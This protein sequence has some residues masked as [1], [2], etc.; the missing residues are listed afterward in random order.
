MRGLFGSIEKRKKPGKARKRP[1]GDT[2][3]P[4]PVINKNLFGKPVSTKGDVLGCDGCPLNK[5]PGTNKVKRLEYITGR[6]AMLWAMCPGRWENKREKELVGKSGEFLWDTLESFDLHRNSFDVQNVVRCQ[7]KINPESDGDKNNRE[8]TKQELLCCS[9][10]N[11][12]ALERNQGRAKVHL[13][14]GE[15]AATQLLGKEFK[16]KRMI[17]WHKGW[18]C[19]IV[20]NYHPSYFTRQKGTLGM[21]YFTWRDR[22]RAVAAIIQNPGRWGYLKKQDYHTVRTLGEFDEMEKHLREEAAAN[23]RVSFDI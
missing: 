18:D 15:V 12:E 1:A 4:L 11:E 6:R 10:Y 5:Q 7:P 16:S 14:L 23:R 20:R 9:V 13:I 22:F 8:P 2:P 3:A 21:D 19:Y 17:H